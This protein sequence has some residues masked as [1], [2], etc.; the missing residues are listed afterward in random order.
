MLWRGGS[1]G[2]GG[3]W[4]GMWWAAARAPLATWML[5]CGAMAGVWAEER[6]PPPEFSQHQLPPTVVPPARAEWLAWLDVG[7]LLVALCLAVWL[8][9]RRRWRRGVFALMV[10]CILYFGFYRKG[11]IC[12]VGSLQ[13]VALACGSG[14]YALPLTVAAFFLLPLAFALF[15]GRVFC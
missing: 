4:R 11:C 6:F 1:D 5:F 8:V 15:Y 10:G 9:H 13:N 2:R 3:V 12:S 7:V 14:N